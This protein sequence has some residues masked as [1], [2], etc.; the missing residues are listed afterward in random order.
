[1]ENTVETEVEHF[2]VCSSKQTDFAI[3]ECLAVLRTFGSEYFSDSGTEDFEH[4]MATA[5]SVAQGV[6]KLHGHTN[7]AEFSF[8]YAVDPI[9]NHIVLASPTPS[10]A[11]A[12]SDAEFYIITMVDLE[13]IFKTP[14]RKMHM[15][16]IA[17]A[18]AMVQT[19]L[20]LDDA[21]SGETHLAN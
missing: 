2:Y 13:P 8:M 21:V 18:A 9:I 1:M 7:Y 11:Q 14:M 12:N 5:S 6:L 10:Y 16:D 19:A 17:A 4:N 15:N 3:R 20:D